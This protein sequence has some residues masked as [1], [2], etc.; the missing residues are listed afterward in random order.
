M[1]ETAYVD[2]GDNDPRATYQKMNEAEKGSC[3]S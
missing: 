1:E 2:G 3:R